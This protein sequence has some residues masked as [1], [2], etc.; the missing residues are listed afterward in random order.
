MDIW[1]V[2][3]DQMGNTIEEPYNLGK[4]VNSE[5]DEVTPFFHETSSTLFFSSNGHKSI[6]GL[7]IFKCSYDRDTES[8]TGAVNLGEPINSARDD[9]Y[10]IWDVF[11]KR[12][13][14]SSDREECE[15]GHCFDIYEV[16]NEPIKIMIEGLS[17]DA[18]TDEILP[19]AKITF[20]DVRFNFKPFEVITDD[21][22]FYELELK[23]DMEIFMKG[24][25]KGY[26]ADAANVDTRGITETTVI[27]QDFF[28]RGIPTGE[29]E[30][31]GIEYDFD[32]DKLRDNSL[33][34]LD[35]TSKEKIYRATKNIPNIK[36][37]DVNHF[38]AFD[39]VK[40]KKIIFTESSIKELEKRYS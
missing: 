24:T 36:I 20:K 10:M 19:N 17:F 30:I 26:F 16:L 5:F 3:I 1:A 2:G 15:N 22:G 25:K 34:I 7:D 29:I 8:Y 33:V 14:F 37:T 4:M 31:K 40:F 18:V 9:S 6:G 28:L 13:F 35:K 23:Q 21:D 12:G 32:S 38:S 11:L 39:I 27:T